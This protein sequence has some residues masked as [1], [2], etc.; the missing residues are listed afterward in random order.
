[1]IVRRGSTYGVS[2]Y[3]A[4]LKRKRWVGTFETLRDAREAER[5]ASR[6]RG[7]AAP[8]DV[9]RVRGSVAHELRSTRACD[10]ADIRVRAARLC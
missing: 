10:T 6:R 5:N 8:I 2:V 1:M 4:A 9:S 7:S 3:D